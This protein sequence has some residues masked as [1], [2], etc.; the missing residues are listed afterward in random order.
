M[1]ALIYVNDFSAFLF[2]NFCLLSFCF[3][4]T[5]YIFPYQHNYTYTPQQF[6]LS[7]S[8]QIFSFSFD[9]NLLLLYRAYVRFFKFAS[10]FYFCFNAH[11]IYFF[12]T[13]TVL[14]IFRFDLS[15][16]LVLKRLLIIKRTHFSI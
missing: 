13:C 2:S 12:N 7:S 15:I 3:H 6:T 11:T 4:L 8:F 5:H 1:C 16:F 14:I 9:V 10:F